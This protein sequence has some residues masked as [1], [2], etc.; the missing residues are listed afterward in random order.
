ML[1]QLPCFVRS[2]STAFFCSLKRHS[3]PCLMLSVQCGNL[4]APTVDSREHAQA[5]ALPS[6][7]SQL[8]A[9]QVLTLHHLLCTLALQSLMLLLRQK[10]LLRTLLSVLHRLCS[11]RCSEQLQKNLKAG[12][13]TQLRKCMTC[14]LK[15]MG[16]KPSSAPSSRGPCRRQLQLTPGALDCPACQTY[17]V[18]RWRRQCCVLKTH[19]LCMKAESSLCSTDQCSHGF[20]CRTGSAIGLFQVAAP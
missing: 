11:P 18:R 5:Q 19:H 4:Q 13:F 9:Q 6:A 16:I 3:P 20:Y 2:K 1:L 7:P 10:P 8:Q 15:Q 17:I 12:H 14:A